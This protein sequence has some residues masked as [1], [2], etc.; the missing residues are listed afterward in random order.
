MLLAAG[1][2]IIVITFASP[3][4]EG[5][6]ESPSLGKGLEEMGLV[7]LPITQNLLSAMTKFVR[8]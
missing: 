2:V 3:T 4:F 5:S 8:H 1:L 6:A 7:G